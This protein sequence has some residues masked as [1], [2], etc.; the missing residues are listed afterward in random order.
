MVG[1]FAIG[2]TRNWKRNGGKKMNIEEDLDSI[3]KK[4]I[5]GILGVVL[6]VLVL[7]CLFGTFYT[8]RSGEEGVLL[9]FAKASE[10]AVGAGIHAKVPMVQGVVKFD[11]KTQKYQ[12]GAAAA[13]KDLQDVSTDVAVN[14]HLTAGMTPKI[15]TELGKNY[16]EKVIMPSVQ[17]VVKAVTAKY[18]A[19]ELITR[20]AEVSNDIYNSLRERLQNR[21]IMVE[22]IAITNF[23]FSPSFTQA[24]EAKV[25]AEQ[26]SLE[27]KNLLEK[28]KYEAEQLRSQAA[29][30]RDAAIARAT[31]EA[32]KVRLVQMQ[33]MQSPQYIEYVKASRWDGALPQF[34]M[35][36]SSSPL[37]MDMP[38]MFSGLA[39]SG[40]S[41]GTATS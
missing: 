23:Q 9:T 31:G 33:L 34:Y 29:G 25:T 1:G 26:A 7:V 30:E 32:E 6:V 2:A 3:K 21:G 39:A 11:V 36:G 37:I 41:N 15:F 12:V 19:E 10:T 27:Q 35:T 4:L 22:S 5:S 40:T 20:R 8:V 17:E 14:Y 28:V 18:T 24:I 16:E 38:Q 13:S